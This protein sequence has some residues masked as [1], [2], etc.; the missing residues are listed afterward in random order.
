MALTRQGCGHELRPGARSCTICQAQTIDGRDFLPASGEPVPSYQAA[1]V[2]HAAPVEPA[3]YQ[4][5]AAPPVPYQ[6]TSGP[7]GLPPDRPRR[8]RSLLLG[9]VTFLAA[10]AVT[11]AV[12]LIM[13]P[14]QRGPAPGPASP[15]PP[16]GTASSSASAPASSPAAQPA[17]QQ[18]AQS[19]AGLLAQS[20]TDRSS[21]VAAVNDV[22]QC[23]PNLH[24]D[25]QIFQAAVASRQDLLSRLASLPDRSALP[26]TMLA[27]LT[28]A[29]QNSIKADQYYAQWAQDEMSNGCT[30]NNT[31]DP[32]AQ[33]A[34]G[35]DAQATAGKQAFV[36]GWNP[37]A[38]HYRL[39][40][41]QWNQL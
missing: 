22:S 20:V 15:A 36:S 5:P 11:A 6:T 29:W 34:A 12:M 18:A 37:I 16:G 13:H 8:L 10:G 30:S 28:S 14:L 41:Y 2:Y 31:S 9:L 19:L 25:P 35:P 17:Q 7:P 3:R 24:Q 23:G 32:N 33:A 27:A 4:P 26:A 38:A 1:P 21:I 40:T 39:P